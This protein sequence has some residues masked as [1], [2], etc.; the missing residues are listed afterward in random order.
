MQEERRLQEE[1]E[2]RAR[3]NEEEGVVANNIYWRQAK[4]LSIR[5]SP[6]HRIG[7]MSAF[8]NPRPT[9]SLPRAKANK[10]V[11]RIGFLFSQQK[12]N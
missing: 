10:D 6:T 11:L 7:G 4:T 1:G 8:V 5:T 2:E 9:E 12:D 3:K